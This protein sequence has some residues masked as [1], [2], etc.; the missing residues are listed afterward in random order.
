MCRLWRLRAAFPLSLAVMAGLV[1]AL[2][3]GRARAQSSDASS[4]AEVLFQEGRRLADAGNYAEACPKFAESHRLEPAIG[5]L[6]NLGACHQK[7]GKL[8]TAWSELTTALAIGKRDGRA[9]VTEYAA[10]R[11][12]EL[13]PQL[14]KLR[15]QVAPEHQLVGLEVRLDGQLLL[16]PAWG[17]EAPIDPGSHTLSASAPGHAS[18][19]IELSLAAGQMRV[20]AVP[21]LSAVETTPA[22]QTAPLPPAAPSGGALSPQPAEPAPKHDASAWP[23]QKSWAVALAGVGVLGI[24]TSMG[25]GLSAKSTFDDS[26]SHCD[27]SGC[28]ELGLGLRHDAVKR[29]RVATVVFAVGGAA[30][31]GGAVLWLTAPT[32]RASDRMALRIGVTPGSVQAR[33]SW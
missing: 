2:R 31:A 9:D 7:E 21:L 33:V 29:G 17:V 30:L 18:W 32:P 14:P 20:E 8:A 24:G 26:A 25:L 27:D 23:S 16:R 3:V 13:A 28:D 5:T 15:I 22:A 6:L 12:E 4:V 19:S 10:A 1:L 11:I